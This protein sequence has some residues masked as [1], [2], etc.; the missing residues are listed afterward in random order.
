MITPA[1]IKAGGAGEEVAGA[2]AAGGGGGG[3]EEQE[4]KASKAAGS[5]DKA[6]THRPLD[7]LEAA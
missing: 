4:A 1:S 6:V 5:R 3:G 7:V 2:W